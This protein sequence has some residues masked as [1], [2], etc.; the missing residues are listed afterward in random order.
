M[1]RKLSVILASSPF[2]LSM[3]KGERRVFQQLNLCYTIDSFYLPK[4]SVLAGVL[5]SAAKR[6]SYRVDF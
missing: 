5:L 1:K 2:F 3:S 4:T 6:T